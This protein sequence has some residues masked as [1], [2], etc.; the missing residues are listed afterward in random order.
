MTEV[1]AM[2]IQVERLSHRDGN[3]SGKGEKFLELCSE[4]AIEAMNQKYGFRNSKRIPEEK[5][6]NN[7]HIWAGFMAMY[8]ESCLTLC[9]II[10]NT[11]GVPTPVKSSAWKLRG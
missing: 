3:F 8:F 1:A 2:G 6:S 5:G 10:G 7:N 11:I 4:Q 9:D